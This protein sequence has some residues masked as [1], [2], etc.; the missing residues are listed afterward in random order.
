MKIVFFSRPKARQFDYKPRYYDVEKERREQRK[1]EL[2]LGGE[3]TDK[4]AMFKGELQQRWRSDRKAEKERTRRR[5]MIYLI[6]I[7]VVAYYIFFTNF[8][9]KFVSL[10]TAF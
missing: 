7:A 3:E 4:R 10:I 6:L 2:G 8:I 5:T 1:K 9:Q